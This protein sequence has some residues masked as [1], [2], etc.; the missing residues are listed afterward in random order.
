MKNLAITQRLDQVPNRE[1][2]RSS[3]D[4]KI[5]DFLKVL[6]TW[7]PTLV[8]IFQECGDANYDRLRVWL[9]ANKPDGLV[10]TGGGNL[11]ES[12]IRDN[13]EFYLLDYAFQ[14]RIPVLGICRGMQ[15]MGVRAGANVVRVSGHVA[16]NHIIS[17]QINRVVNSYHN[18]A[19][20]GCPA[21]FRVL[22]S[23]EDGQIEA[24]R[25]IS[26]KWEGWMWH[27]ERNSTFAQDDLD[28]LCSIFLAEVS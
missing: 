9:K 27:P 12:M 10:L 5:L 8:P 18:F 14:L 24:I 21:D 23:A 4:I 28:R 22:A 13:L 1:E 6:D 15:I 7:V 16:T 11:G 17:G 19:L 2:F 25:H 20:D 26:L 3:T